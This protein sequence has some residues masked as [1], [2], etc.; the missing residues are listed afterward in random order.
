MKRTIGLIVF[1]LGTFGGQMEIN[2]NSRISRLASI[3]CIALLLSACGSS[4]SSE[5]YATP[6]T[7]A[8]INTDAI[9]QHTGL[10][11]EE[12]G[13]QPELEDGGD[14]LGGSDPLFI[15]HEYTSMNTI[16]FKYFTYTADEDG[17]VIVRIDYEAEDEYGVELYVLDSEK[18][19]LGESDAEDSTHQIVVFK[20]KK[21]E[22][23]DVRV[24]GRTTSLTIK[25]TTLN[26]ETLNITAG[27]FLGIFKVDGSYYCEYYDVNGDIV[28]E[29]PDSWEE[30]MALVF[31]F[32]APY[33]RDLASSEKE[34]ITASGN[35]FT[36]IIA[37]SDEW[38]ADD[39]AQY[40]EVEAGTIT[41]TVDAGA[42]TFTGKAV[43]EETYYR[44]GVYDGAC[45]ESNTI[46]DGKF[47]LSK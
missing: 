42:A 43:S 46:T 11:Q 13:S 33:I 4:K 12:I 5:N 3:A 36:Y 41:F 20:A 24:F 28:V 19:Y 26:A 16:Y 18:N 44:D 14:L 34:P 1:N 39:G 38:E 47:I 25:L 15:N 29:E 27:E 45:F 6:V 37:D 22:E 23:Y 9:A 17:Y 10:T 7:A 21:Y 32:D 8:D 2:F 30:Y 40:T 31:N 35:I